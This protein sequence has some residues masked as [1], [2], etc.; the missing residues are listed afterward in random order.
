M[1]NQRFWDTCDGRRTGAG[2]KKTKIWG[3]IFLVMALFTIWA[4]IAQSKSFSFAQFQ[5]TL[6]NSSVG[7]MIAASVSMLGFIVF[8]GMALLCIVKALG[9]PRRFTKGFLYSAADIYFSAITPSA[10][11]GQPA[12]AYFMM[13][14]GVPGKG[15][16][17]NGKD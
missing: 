4:V 2:M 10:T 13:Q 16:H 6:H 12:S 17:R 5:D 3:L 11:G 9:Y 8:E 14:D 15:G 7:W 1:D